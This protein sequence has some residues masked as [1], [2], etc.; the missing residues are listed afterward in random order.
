MAYPKIRSAAAAVCAVAVLTLSSQ[1]PA[2][3]VPTANTALSHAKNTGAQSLLK[4]PP[5][6][7]AAKTC[8]TGYQGTPPNCV[9]KPQWDVTK[10]KPS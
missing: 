3:N 10:N 2:Q 8:P 7:P 9:K 4:A 5:A 6:P 1:V